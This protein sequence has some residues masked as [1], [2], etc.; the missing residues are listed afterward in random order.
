ML[1]DQFMKI[2]LAISQSQQLLIFFCCY[3]Y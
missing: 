1:A 3:N 2:I